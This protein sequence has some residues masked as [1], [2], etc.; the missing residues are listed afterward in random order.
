MYITQNS[1]P[2]VNCGGLQWAKIAFI[3]CMVLA[4]VLSDFGKAITSPTNS[5]VF[6]Q[7]Q[8][9]QIR[10]V[11]AGRTNVSISLYKDNAFYMTI[12]NQAPDTGTLDWYAPKAADMFPPFPSWDAYSVQVG[13]NR[14]P[15]F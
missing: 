3:A 7:G 10:W 4:L 13:T 15:N 9:V 5:Q 6:A 12:T 8:P 11:P 14:S 2:T 1:A